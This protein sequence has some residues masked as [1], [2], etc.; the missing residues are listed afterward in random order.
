[1]KTFAQLTFVFFFAVLVMIRCSQNPAAP[2]AVDDL[3]TSPLGSDGLDPQERYGE[4]ESLA[5]SLETSTEITLD[6]SSGQVVNRLQHAMQD[7]NRLLRHVG[8]FV[9]QS[10]N[11]SSRAVFA[12]ALAARDSASAAI[13]AHDVRAAFEY[14]R[15]SRDLALEAYRIISGEDPPSRREV[16]ERL[17]LELDELDHLLADVRQQME[18]SAIP[19]IRRLFDRALHHRRLAGES[20]HHGELRKAGHHIRESRRYALAVLRILEENET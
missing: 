5:A 3:F 2:A 14:I 13:G 16:F 17:V 19:G 18:G 6:D 4:I 11:D 20:L 12:E 8:I 1:M 15:E 7:L 10:G 9:E